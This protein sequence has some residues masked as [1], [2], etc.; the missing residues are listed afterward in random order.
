MCNS[1]K[2]SQSAPK[3]AAHSQPSKSHAPEATSGFIFR[4]QF[5]RFNFWY[6]FFSDSD[7]SSQWVSMVHLVPKIIFQAIMIINQDFDFFWTYEN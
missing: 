4:K 5:S 1:S 7:F 2:N 6:V 3:T